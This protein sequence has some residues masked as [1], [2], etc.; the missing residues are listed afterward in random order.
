MEHCQKY[1]WI[2]SAGLNKTHFCTL[3]ENQFGWTVCSYQV[4][5]TVFHPFAYRHTNA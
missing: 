1:N 4:K 5:L 2:Q 3:K